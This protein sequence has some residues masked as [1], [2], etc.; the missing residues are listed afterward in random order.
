MADPVQING[1]TVPRAQYLLAFG[2]DTTFRRTQTIV[3]ATSLEVIPADSM[4]IGIIFTLLNAGGNIFISTVAP[5]DESNAI[6]VLA[7]LESQT[8]L[9]ADVGSLVKVP[10]NA[11][12]D[13]FGSVLVVTEILVLPKGPNKCA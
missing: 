2:R 13:A 5:A 7:P 11:R 6:I 10:W 1:V 8:L 3:A 9:A 4:R 12:Q